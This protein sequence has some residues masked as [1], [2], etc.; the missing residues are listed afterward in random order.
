MD[1][2]Q[3]WLNEEVLRHMDD[4][5]KVAELM[6][7]NVERHESATSTVRVIQKLAKYVLHATT[8]ALNE[9]TPAHNYY[10]D[11]VVVSRSG[12]LR[13]VFHVRGTDIQIP[14]TDF[15]HLAHHEIGD[16]ELLD[17]DFG[18]YALDP[19]WLIVAANESEWRIDEVES[20]PQY[21]SP[22]QS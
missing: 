18:T 22:E 12:G 13:C 4:L 15:H 21:Q 17:M 3:Q 16:T 2:G 5:N 9:V 19:A 8:L 20:L 10:C 14:V 7:S 11:Y 1:E 6:R